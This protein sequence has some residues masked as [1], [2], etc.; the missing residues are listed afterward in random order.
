MNVTQPL[1]HP[2]RMGDLPLANRIVMAP[3]TR[4]RATD[5]DLAPTEMH[6]RYY[7]QRASAGLIITEGTW[8]SP[9]AI[10]WHDVPGLFTETQVRGWSAVTDAVHCEGGVIFAQL[11]HTGALSH[12]DFF[13]GV[14]PLAPS[15]VNPGQHSPTPTGNK[16]TV[17]P[18]TMTR[19]E[20]RTTIA[21][22]ATAAANAKR[23]GFDG[24]QIQAGFSYL[25][26]QFLNPATNLR[27]DEYGGSIANRARLLFD[28]LDA[29]GERIDI[30]RVGVKVGPAWAERGEFRSTVDTLATSEYIVERL[31][32]YPL[33]HWLLMGAMAT[34]EG[35]PL[36]ALQGDRMFTHFRP[37]YRG[38]LIANVGMTRERGNQLIT[39]GLADL[40]AFGEPFIAN[41]DLPTR[42]TTNAPI[43]RSDHAT[44]YT[45]GAHG[46]IDYP[47]HDGTTAAAGY[48]SQEQGKLP[49]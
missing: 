6:A 25:I 19:D 31:N 40:V 3:L 2:Y 28:V 42:F 45:P 13:H 18:R 8:I 16:P 48:A 14:P 32:D 26:S 29:I 36:E 41:P 23:A 21:D 35:Q 30:G 15:A 46:Y 43:E 4:S 10:G 39:D 38:T 34:L 11:W 47:P 7:A 5:P 49:E 37:R 27:D 17:V 1:L 12:P 33:A 22:Y 24:V 20:V 9:Q 44:H